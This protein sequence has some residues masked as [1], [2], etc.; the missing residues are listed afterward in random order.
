M[1]YKRIV[2]REGKLFHLFSSGCLLCFSGILFF[3]LV[4]LKSLPLT[5]FEESCLCL[6][7]ISNENTQ[8][9]QINLSNEKMRAHA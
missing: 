3:S 5:N 8:K 4:T 1:Y 7:Q 2:K 6:L 9:A